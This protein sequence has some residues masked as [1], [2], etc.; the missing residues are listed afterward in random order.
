MRGVRPVRAQV[1]VW[2]AL[3]L[4]A[5]AENESMKDDYEAVVCGFVFVVLT[6]NVT[7]RERGACS[8]VMCMSDE[9]KRRLIG[10]LSKVRTVMTLG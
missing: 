2:L 4:D 6:E 3:E 8:R 7:E 5:M 1:K 9:G 10:V